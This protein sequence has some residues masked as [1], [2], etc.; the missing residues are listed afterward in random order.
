MHVLKL[1]DEEMA[2]ELNLDSAEGFEFDEAYQPVFMMSLTSWPTLQLDEEGN[3]L[4]DAGYVTDES[5]EPDTM[6]L[7]AQLDEGI[8]GAYAYRWTIGGAT[9]RQLMKSGI[10]YLVLKTGDHVTVLPTEGFLAGERY[11]ELKMQGTSTRRFTYDIVMKRED[12]SQADMPDDVLYT[13]DIYVTV[14]EQTT[15]L[16]SEE[17]AELYLIN[18]FSGPSQLMSVP[19]GLW[20]DDMV[21]DMEKEAK[22]E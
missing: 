18:V 14:D 22:E 2:L 13:S 12:A 11:T 20:T 9:M 17:S 3:A 4:P 5:T 6:L 16:G 1:D 19:Y 10:K 7:D 15:L 8:T 21:L